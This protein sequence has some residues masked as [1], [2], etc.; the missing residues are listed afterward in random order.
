MAI[1]K[2]TIRLEGVEFLEKILAGERD[3]VG[4]ELPKG[5]LLASFFDAFREVRNYLE[6]NLEDLRDNPIDLSESKIEY[7]RAKDLYLPYVKAE[8]A[9]FK[10]SRFIRSDWF[11]AFLEN[12]SFEDCFLR[13]SDFT[14]AHLQGAE[15]KGAKLGE[16][17]FENADLR[18]ARNLD[19][20]KR[21]GSSNFSN[22]TISTASVDALRKRI[23]GKVNKPYIII[24]PQ[25]KRAEAEECH[26]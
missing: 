13:G 18:G 24:D 22:T 23:R 8:N 17:N 14:Y 21:L 3:F 16:I 1:S 19:L 26:S 6:N 2:M 4:I 11:A 7:V 10:G 9:C 20:T 12:A 5:L 25:Y 15:F